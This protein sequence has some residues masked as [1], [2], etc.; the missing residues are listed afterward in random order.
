MSESTLATVQFRILNPRELTEREWIA[1]QGLQ[2]ET[3]AEA[4]STRTEAEVA[5][6]VQWGN[7][8]GFCESRRHPEI[9]AEELGF[10]PGLHFG[11]H[12]IVTAH[13]A[14]EDGEPELVGFA[15]SAQVAKATHTYLSPGVRLRSQELGGPIWLRDLVVRPN[16]QR[17]Y[18]A[19]ALMALVLP[20]ADPAPPLMTASLEE[21]QAGSDFLYWGAEMRPN[22]AKTAPIQAF[23]PGTE[24]AQ[25]RYW[26]AGTARKVRQAVTSKINTTERRQLETVR[27]SVSPR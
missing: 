25:L 20:D 21:S 2:R 14:G 27:A 26:L 16:M 23:G 10:G 4:L 24:P 5:H 15:Y 11:D 3:F 1:V 9:A 19:S 22:L 17:R 13:A 12:R 7:A 8:D 18:V 6:F